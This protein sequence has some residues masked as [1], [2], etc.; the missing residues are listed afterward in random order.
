MSSAFNNLKEI[1]FNANVFKDKIA[2]LKQYDEK[3]GTNIVN[4]MSSN[5]QNFED[6][7]TSNLQPISVYGSGVDTALN[8]QVKETTEL[9]NDLVQQITNSNLGCGSETMDQQIKRELSAIKKSIYN[10]LINKPPKGKHPKQE[11]APHGGKGPHGRRKG[12]KFSDML[13]YEDY[14]SSASDKSHK[15]HE[16]KGKP[17][18][19]PGEFTTFTLMEARKRRSKK[20]SK[21]ASKKSSKKSSKKKSKKRHSK[22]SSRMAIM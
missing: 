14:S 22:K 3:Y 5:F 18:P 12:S 7:F 6:I 15:K 16:P 19:E 4:N 2:K 13:N 11:L 17:M 10:R 20:A 1:S 8:G 21:K 9:Y